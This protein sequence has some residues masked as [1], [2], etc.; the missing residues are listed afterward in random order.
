MADLSDVT[1]SPLRVLSISLAAACALGCSGLEAGIDYPDTPDFGHLL[2][3]PENEK[4]PAISFNSFKVTN[5][6]CPNIDTHPVTQKLGQDEL[7]RYFE[8]QGLRVPVKKARS[9]LYWF[10]VPNG[11]RRGSFVRLRLAVLDS[12]PL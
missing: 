6:A 10:D 2:R 7:Q 8:A 3:T 12:Q 11:D 5:E 9:N 4:G 1:P